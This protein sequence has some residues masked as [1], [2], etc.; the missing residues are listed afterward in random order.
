[1]LSFHHIPDLCHLKNNK[2]AIKRVEEAIN[3]LLK[4]KCMEMYSKRYCIN[5]LTVAEC[6]KLRFVLDMRQ[7][8]NYLVVPIFKYENLKSLFIIFEQGYY[9]FTLLGIATKVATILAF[10]E[11]THN[12]LVSFG[13]F[14]QSSVISFS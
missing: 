2:S 9:F 14:N 3:K 6:K 13:H 12:I 8:K 7:V 11:N 10:S 1:M 4:D 5:S